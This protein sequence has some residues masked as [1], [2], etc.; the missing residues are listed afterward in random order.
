MSNYRYYWLGTDRT[1]GVNCSI[2]VEIDDETFRLTDLQNCSVEINIDEWNE[3]KKHV[4]ENKELTKEFEES[5]CFTE[6][7]KRNFI[8][9]VMNDEFELTDE[10]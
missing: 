5:L 4:K 3:L 10:T 9:S 8:Y 6:Y 1:C 7:E 2:K